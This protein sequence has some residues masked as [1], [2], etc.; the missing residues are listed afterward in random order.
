MKQLLF[1]FALIPALAACGRFPLGQAR[2]TSLVIA[3]PTV[4]AQAETPTK[5]PTPVALPTRTSAPATAASVPTDPAEP[6]P[7]PNTAAPTPLSAEAAQAATAQEI[8]DIV[9]PLRDDVRLAVAYRGASPTL[10]TPRAPIAYEVGM[11]ES[12]FIGN[13][14]SNTVSEIEAELM[15]IGD[16]AYFWFDLGRGSIQ[17][18]AR[19]LAEETAAF[20]DIYDT[21]FTYFGVS[22]PEGGRVH[23][24]HASP[25]A[26]CDD[27]NSCGLAGYYSSS[28]MLPRTIDPK[29][30]ERAM[31]VM[32]TQQFGGNNYLDVLAHE[33]RHM[34]GNGFEAGEEDWFVEGG[35][36]LAEELAGFD[37]VPQWRGNLFLQNPDQQLNSWTE[38]NSIPYYGQGYLV[39]RY[40]YQRLGAELYREFMMSNQPGLRAVDDV[41][42]AN[43]LDLTGEGL[44]LDWLVAMALTG[45]PSAPESY[46]W[47]G[48]GLGPVMAEAVNTTPADFDTTVRQYAADYYALPSSGEYRITFNGTPTVP[49]LPGDAPSG[50]FVWYAQRANDSNPR[51]T[52]PLDLRDVG[53]ATLRYDV[54]VDI[55]HGYDFAYVAVSADGG[56]TWQALEAGNMQGLDPADDP[57]DSAF[58]ARFYTGR[59]QQWMSE[60]VDLTPFAGQEILLRFEYVTDPILTYSGFAVDNITVPEIDFLDDAETLDSGWT[61]EGF[62]R[63]TTELPQSWWLQLITF[64]SDGA[65]SVERVAVPPDGRVELPVAGLAGERRPMLIVSATAPET[66]AA[67]KYT[68]HVDSH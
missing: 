64:D 30:N 21:L 37:A 42:A 8:A 31:F 50:A 23:I 40:L 3:T 6:P 16:N 10:P 22:E 56:Q 17:P 38:G 33:L 47:S 26:L 19:K 28:D 60:A 15:S 25:K 18:D 9:P 11:R 65:P 32:N 1:I 51:L 59:V 53:A 36:L 2:P 54:Y 20:D 43:D 67:G 7:M 24:I 61:A 66:L 46:T 27:P 4:T 14:D 12:F 5:P 62:T 39:N 44:W 41:A 58:A 45:H 29:S 68:L 49:L 63:A 55:E 35:A 52:R 13:V 48:P 57:S 34:L